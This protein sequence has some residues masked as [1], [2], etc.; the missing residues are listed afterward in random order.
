MA[1]SNYLDSL[2]RKIV[3]LTPQRFHEFDLSTSLIE[4]SLEPLKG[5]KIQSTIVI[6]YPWLCFL[7]TFLI[8]L[9]SSTYTEME[10]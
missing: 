6:T 8:C 1:S 9:Q 10:Q 5:F 4:L 2:C 7:E 3:A